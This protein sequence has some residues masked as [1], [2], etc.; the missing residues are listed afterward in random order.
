M[1]DFLYY[2][3]VYGEAKCYQE[4]LATFFAMAEELKLK[5]LMGSDTDAEGKPNISQPKKETKK[6]LATQKEN[7]QENNL[8]NIFTPV[9]KVETEAL[10]GTKA[11]ADFIA[12]ADLQDIDDR[13]K[14]MM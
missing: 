9:T 6:K 4:N 14:S 7:H 3:I 11:A 1:V 5:G 2:A 8:P 13:V 10:E 12:T